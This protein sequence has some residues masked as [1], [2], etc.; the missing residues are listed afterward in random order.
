MINGLLLVIVAL[1][2]LCYRKLSSIDSWL[3]EIW[4]RTP[5]PREHE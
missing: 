2:V 1:L 4:L 5:V 3:E